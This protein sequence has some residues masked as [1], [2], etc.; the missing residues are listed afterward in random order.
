MFG[1]DE[2]RRCIEACTTVF[3]T[4]K[5]VIKNI[6]F[7]DTA[8]EIYFFKHVKPQIVSRYFYQLKLLQIEENIPVVSREKRIALYQI[9]VTKLDNY[10]LSHQEFER[11]MSRG[12]TYMDEMYFTRGY[13]E[14]E[15]FTD[16]RYI[17]VDHEVA[18]IKG[19]VLTRL[20][21]NK[22][23]HQ[24]LSHK[25]NMLEQNGPEVYE[26]LEHILW[27]GSKTDL[28]V[29]M[30]GLVETNQVD[31]D[32]ATLAR[33]FQRI[34]NVDLNRFYRL[35]T[36]VKARKKDRLPIL[37]NMLERLEAKIIEDA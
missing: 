18:T 4:I 29:L 35:W 13:K 25:I 10:P 22:K 5:G 33:T 7:K 6:K 30:Y 11:Y 19:F 27:K 32:I 12:E 17:D 23:L 14:M 3:I 34:F 2:L 9:E 26:R 20:Q 8:E 37:K 24:Y 36:D 1:N 31:C 15:L 16:Y 28:V 21:A